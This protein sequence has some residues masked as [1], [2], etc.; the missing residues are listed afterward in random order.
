MGAKA[1]EA[2]AP[3]STKGITEWRGS[4]LEAEIKGR[5]RKVIPTFHPASV[6]YQWVP[7]RVCLDRDFA[8]ICEESESPTH[9]FA[10]RNYIK[11]D[12]SNIH[13]TERWTH[14]LLENPALPLSVDIE[15]TISDKRITHVGFAVEPT[16]GVSFL[17][18][19]DTDRY[20]RALLESPNPKVMQNGVNFDIQLLSVRGYRV[21]NMWFDTLCAQHLLYVELPRSLAFLCAWYTDQPYYKHLD[22]DNMEQYNAL[23][24][25]VTLE[26]S[27]RQIEHLER[28]NKLEFYETYYTKLLPP[29]LE[30]QVEGVRIDQEARKRLLD[31][32]GPL[33]EALQDQIAES[34]PCD[35]MPPK[36]RNRQIKLQDRL[37]RII[38]DDRMTRKDGEFT[39]VYKN[40]KTALENFE[41]ER[42]NPESD[43]Q[44]KDILYSHYKI[45]PRRHR[46]AVTVNERALKRIIDSRAKPEA[47]ELCERILEYRGMSKIVSTYLKP[48]ID[49]D[50]RARTTYNL[51]KAKTG[52]LTSEK[53]VMGTGFNLQNIPKRKDLEGGIRGFFLPDEGDV[54]LSADLSQAEARVV[55]CLAGEEEQIS[56][57]ERGEDLFTWMASE[58]YECQVDKVTKEMRANLKVANHGTNYGM[59]LQTFAETIGGD[60]RALRRV[61]DRFRM[62]FPRL[63]AWR[64]STEET[65]RKRR[66]LE[67]PLGRWRYFYDRTHSITWV[68]GAKHFKPNEPYM[69]DAYSYVP[70]STV[71][72][73]LNLGLW[74]GYEAILQHP[75]AYHRP[76]FRLQIH[77]QVI[78]SVHPETVEETTEI[79]KETMEIPIVVNGYDLTIPIDIQ[80]GETW[81]EVS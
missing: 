39:A 43:A 32:M 9:E 7:Q 34:I 57:F 36:E 21:N 13:E 41:P 63:Q 28:I 75:W 27:E 6:V 30:A 38:A 59:T 16:V 8:R 33:C 65:I 64:D 12:G 51:G 26:V 22:K 80:I 67:T 72:D 5:K 71:G 35:W 60:M 46:G 14:Y 40:T 24:A 15:S 53:N 56:R 62:L 23:D 50:S 69:R 25:M 70:Q 76:R 81:H 44:V 55:A 37:E 61:W 48:P 47:R 49:S 68:G 74:K 18:N 58:A 1:L 78:Y 2:I 3:R 11:I 20:I 52:R 79:L 42:F 10:D 45:Y 54:F 31:D 66:K 29:L 19:R 4:I 77:D 73:L 17:V